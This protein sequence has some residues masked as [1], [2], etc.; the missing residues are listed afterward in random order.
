MRA[1]V[2]LGVGVLAIS[3]SAVF[4]RWTRMPGLASAFWRML[5]ASGALW[6]VLAV[7][8]AGRQGLSRASL[9]LAGLGGVFFAGDIGLYNLSV[10][11]T[12]AGGATFLGNNAPLVVGLLTWGLTRR[13]PPGRFWVAL[14]LQT[15]G[16]LCIVWVDR[17]AMARRAH[18]D[19]L[20]LLTSVCFALYLLTTERLRARV[21]TLTL[22]AL[23]SSASAA[24]LGAVA[25]G[26]GVSLRVPSGVSL[27]CVVG[28]GVVC[29][30]TGYLCL[31]YA[32][33]HLPATV[34]SVV[35][36]GVAPLT[37]AWARV[38]FRERMTLVQWV[39][40]GLI[41]LGIWV[42]GRGRRG[43]RA[44]VAAV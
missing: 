27:A 35:L 11:Q 23:S 36:R 20:A 28:L 29:Q 43:A 24:V 38:C 17:G 32:L 4:V 26:I 40:G 2:V 37:A 12:T 16:A 14:G 3:W 34:S 19:G 41:L 25:L 5:V 33:G 7:R 39:G 13:A 44:E 30:V 15:A 6:G 22:V 9:L 1:F 42:V 10:L 18:G 21:D 8:P 31:T